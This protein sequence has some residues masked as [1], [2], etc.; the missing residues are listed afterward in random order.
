YVGKDYTL[1]A[2][3]KIQQATVYPS[4]DQGLAFGA[5]AATPQ[6]TP[7]VAIRLTLNLR[8]K[9]SAPISSSDG[10]LLGTSGPI[11]NTTAPVTI[12][13]TDQTTAWKFLWVEMVTSATYPLGTTGTLTNAIAEVSFVIPPGTGTS[14]GVSVEIRGDALLYTSSI[15]TWRLGLYSDTTG[16]PTCG[17]WH[18]GRLWLSGVVPHRIDASRSNDPFNFAP[19][20]PS[21]LVPGNAGISYTFNAPDTNPIF[22]MVPDQLGIICGTQKGEWLVQAT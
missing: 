16:Y 11:S 18:E 10:T 21:G 22:W 19:T 1:V 8:G 2:D 13:S 6:G 17:T 12:V 15:R 9:S 5:V 4:S 14:T 3:Q 7:A 20:D